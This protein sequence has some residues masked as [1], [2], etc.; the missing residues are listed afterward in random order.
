MNCKICSNRRKI[1]KM[2]DTDCDDVTNSQT[3]WNE[4]ENQRPNYVKK[5]KEYCPKCKEKKK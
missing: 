2:L 4:R 3:G 1:K 5:L